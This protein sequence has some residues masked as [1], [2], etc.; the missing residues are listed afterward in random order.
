MELRSSVRKHS[1]TNLRMNQQI[2]DTIETYIN[3][4]IQRPLSIFYSIICL[5]QSTN[6]MFLIFSYKQEPFS[7][8]STTSNFYLLLP[9]SCVRCL[10]LNNQPLCCFIYLFN[11]IT[12]RSLPNITVIDCNIIYMHNCEL[13]QLDIK[14]SCSYITESISNNTITLAKNKENSQ[15]IDYEL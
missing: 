11:L 8:I 4:Y 2:N 6:I 7:Q 13:T 10:Q 12:L 15:H 5:D 3:S 9:A 1:Y 14:I